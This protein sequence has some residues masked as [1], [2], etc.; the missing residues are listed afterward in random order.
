MCSNL[1]QCLTLL[2]RKSKEEQNDKYCIDTAKANL[3]ALFRLILRMQN[4]KADEECIIVT[5]TC[6]ILRLM[7]SEPCIIL[8]L[9]LDVKVVTSSENHRENICKYFSMLCINEGCINLLE[10]KSNEGTE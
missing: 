7:K 1:C 6:K 5:R 4:S 10:S 3:N 8:P 9:Y 2:E